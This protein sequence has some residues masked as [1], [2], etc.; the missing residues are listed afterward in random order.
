M[1][2]TSIQFRLMMALVALVIGSTACVTVNP[3]EVGIEVRFGKIEGGVLPPGIYGA[4]ISRVT[5]LSTQTQTYTMAGA[6]TEGAADGSVN[7]LARDQLPVNIDVSVMF[8]LDGSRAIAVFRNFGER[9]DNSIVHPLVRTA[10]REA[11]SEFSAVDLIDHR[12]ELQARM[13]TLVRSALAATLQGRGV[14][15]GAVVVDNVLLR[16]IDLPPSIDEAIA[17]VQRQRQATAAST[18]ANLTAEQEA[19][20]ALTVANGDAAALIARTRADAEMLRIRSE[21]QAAANRTIASSLSPEFLQYARIEATRA[22][23]GS[24][25]TRTV[26][27]QGGMSPNMLM[28]VP[29]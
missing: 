17:N 5:T 25:G 12:A 9:Y 6:G 27:L 29:Q 18:Q 8:H 20:R 22:V 2:N 16:N 14:N 7:V 21:S 24:N 13:T 3:G 28:N 10:V 11:A 15:S 1:F 26:F 23:I 4:M 19:A